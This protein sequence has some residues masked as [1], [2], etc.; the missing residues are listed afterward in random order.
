MTYDICV[1]KKID[2]KF[3]AYAFGFDVYLFERVY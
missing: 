2:E 3:K 1:L